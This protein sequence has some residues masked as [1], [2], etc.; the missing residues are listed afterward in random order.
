MI[1]WTQ[2]TF[3]FSADCCAR[4]LLPRR[5]LQMLTS[6]H[7]AAYGFIS[8]V[9]R[10]ALGVVVHFMEAPWEKSPIATDRLLRSI[11]ASTP[12]LATTRSLVGF[13]AHK[14]GRPSQGEAA[15]PL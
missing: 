9:G 10:N 8:N 3:L 1:P 4:I 7:S 14:L 13:P 5:L 6:Q 15:P 11:Q 12:L 2:K